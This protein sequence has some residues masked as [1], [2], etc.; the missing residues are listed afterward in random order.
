MLSYSYII[1]LTTSV[2]N[3]DAETRHPY[4]LLS[5]DT[6]MFTLTGVK[7]RFVNIIYI[8]IYMY[9]TLKNKKNSVC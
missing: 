6:M 8:Y 2:C 9:H 3:G 7:E 4:I 1:V 5:Y